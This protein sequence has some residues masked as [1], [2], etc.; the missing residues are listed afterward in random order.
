MTGHRQ[1]RRPLAAAARVGRRLLVGV[2]VGGGTVFGAKAEH[3]RH[4][5]IPPTM[6]VEHHEDDAAGDGRGT[7]GHGHLPACA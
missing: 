1:R 2:L 4:W 7:P 6:F 3:D 5:S